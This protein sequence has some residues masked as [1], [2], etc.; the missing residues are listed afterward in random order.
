[1]SSLYG[2]SGLGQHHPFDHVPKLADVARPRVGPE[3]LDGIGSQRPKGLPE[4][5][6]EELEEMLRQKDD[7]F[8]PLAQRRH[9]D[10]EHRETKEQVLAKRTLLHHLLKIPVGRGDDPR[11]DPDQLVAADRI[12]LLLLDR[13]Q[14]LDLSV[15]WELP[16]LVEK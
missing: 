9:L 1:M 15:G 6:V 5:G 2:I 7:V 11:I 3:C 8:T 14:E 16:D 13:P 12:V 10:L 4:F